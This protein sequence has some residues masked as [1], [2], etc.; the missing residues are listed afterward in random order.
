MLRWH[1][2]D[3]KNQSSTIDELQN[4]CRHSWGEDTIQDA[5]DLCVVSLYNNDFNSGQSTSSGPA[6]HDIPV[7]LISDKFPFN[8]AH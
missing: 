5:L 6:L 2:A 8:L 4:F 3:D 7:I 1:L